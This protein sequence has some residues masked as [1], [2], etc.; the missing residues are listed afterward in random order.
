VLTGEDGGFGFRT[1]KP[2]G[3]RPCL[4]VL[5]FARG[6]LKPVRTR[7]YLAPL[8]EARADPAL[9]G[10]RA[11]PRI[12]TLVATIAG[13]GEWKWDIRLQGEGETM[14]FAG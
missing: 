8:D 6:L 10:V 12:P 14:F 13:N 2:G 7:V 1:A 5:V 9:A 4:D 3:T 11:S